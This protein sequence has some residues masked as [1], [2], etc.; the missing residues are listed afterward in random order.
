LRGAR[1]LT[2]AVSHMKDL[3]LTLLD[4]AVTAAKLCGPR[5]ACG[6]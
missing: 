6:R 4:L 1:C 3:L 5:V 2:Y